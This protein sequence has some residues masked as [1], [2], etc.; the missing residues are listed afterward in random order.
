MGAHA[1]EDKSASSLS[2]SGLGEPAFRSTP[3]R[4]E[5]QAAPTPGREAEGEGTHLMA[6]RAASAWGIDQPE[7]QDPAP[8]PRT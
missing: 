1:D 2:G 5:I 4:D 3:G 8:T 6:R 7:M